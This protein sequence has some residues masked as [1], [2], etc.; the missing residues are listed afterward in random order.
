LQKRLLAEASAATPGG[1][2]SVA[3]EKNKQGMDSFQQWGR[4]TKKK[5]DLKLFEPE[6]MVSNRV[7]I[8]KDMGGTR[9]SLVSRICVASAKKWLTALDTW[10]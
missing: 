9:S 7:M 10:K 8:K 3:R 6:N 1:L 4:F 5:L 2:F